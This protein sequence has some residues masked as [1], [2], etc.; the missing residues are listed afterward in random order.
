M[1]QM[2]EGFPQLIIQEG[3][4]CMSCQYGKVHQLPYERSKFQA[5]DPLK[6]VHSNIFRLIKQPSMQGYHYMVTF[7]MT[8]YGTYEY[9]SLKKN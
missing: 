7:I 1:K 5:K 4:I 6:L 2:L 3:I 8:T 9:S